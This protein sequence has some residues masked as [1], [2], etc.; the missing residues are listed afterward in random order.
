MGCQLP[1]YMLLTV[2]SYHLNLEDLKKKKK[3][4]WRNV[5]TTQREPDF[6][7]SEGNFELR[8]NIARISGK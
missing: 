5:S 8:E 4:K 3:K 1:F 2:D 6:E 7:F